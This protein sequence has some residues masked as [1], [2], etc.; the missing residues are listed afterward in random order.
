MEIITSILSVAQPLL[1]VSLRTV[2]DREVP[3]KLVIN[4]GGVGQPRDGDPRAAY[5]VYDSEQKTITVH[6]VEYDIP[7]TQ[8][9]MEDA[10][11]PRWLIDR[12]AIGR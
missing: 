5:A 10:G 11:L 2:Y 4:P 12:L 8:R 1:R 9:L 6:R 7:A 3:R